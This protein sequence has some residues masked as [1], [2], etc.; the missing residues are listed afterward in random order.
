MIWLTWRQFRTQAAVVYVTLAVLAVLLAVTGPDLVHLYQVSGNDFTDRFNADKTDKTLYFVGLAAVLALPAIVGVFWGA[1]LITR[2]LDAGT[3]RLVWNQTI[4]RTRWLVTKLTLT[5]LAAMTAAGL[6]SLMVTW[7][8]NP[9]NRAASGGGLPTAP[10]VQSLLATKM[11]PLAFASH[12]IVPVGYAAFAFTLGVTAGAMIRR[13]V[14]AMAATLAIFVAAQVAMPIWVRPHLIP[15]VRVTQPLD[16]SSLPGILIKGDN[17][18]QVTG[19]VNRPGAWVI[20]NQTID[21]N[22]HVFNGPAGP[23][24][25]QGTEKACDTWVGTLH[26]RQVLTYQ[27]VTRYWALQWSELAAFLVLA[28]LL[29]GLC[30]WWVRRHVS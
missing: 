19:A 21:T 3:H 5:G 20:S 24:C 6:L 18:M 16:A 30:F 29:G 1:P 9:I 17:S 22:G 11:T 14:P 25:Q 27:P 13:T 2:E 10:G 12:G 7:W 28:V 4:T 23:A 8:S 26:L 15:P